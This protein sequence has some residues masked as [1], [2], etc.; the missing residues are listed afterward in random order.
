[1]RSLARSVFG[2]LSLAGGVLLAAAVWQVPAAWRG[3]LVTFLLVGLPVGALMIWGKRMHYRHTE[4]MASIKPPES[5]SR[6]RRTYPKASRSLHVVRG[7]G[8]QER[9]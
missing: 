3:Y 4:Y 9:F 6:K 2:L 8:Q 5:R 1:M 7:G